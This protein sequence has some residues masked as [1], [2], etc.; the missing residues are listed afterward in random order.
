MAEATSFPC[1]QCGA[2]L[3]HDASS[4]QLKC[5]F[6]GHSQV[7]DSSDKPPIREHDLDGGYAEEGC[8][9]AAPRPEGPRSLHCG[10]CGATVELGEATISTACPYCASPIQEAQSEQDKAQLPTDGLLPFQVESAA[11]KKALKGWV[12]G[13]WFAPGAFKQMGLRGDLKGQFVPHFT[14]D[15]LTSNRYRGE[16]GDAYYVQVPDNDDDGG[17]HRERRVR[18]SP[19]SGA[20]ERH[21]DDEL[22]CALGDE[23]RKLMKELEPWPLAS[24]QPF[25]PEALAGYLATRY[26]RGLKVCFDEAKMAMDAA[27]Y[28]DA[29]RR[30]GGDEQ[31]VKELRS[32]YNQTTYKSLL[33]PVWMMV[34]RYQSKPYQVVVNACTGEVSGQR[35][36]SWVKIGAT[37]LGVA[38][39]IAAAVYFGG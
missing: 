37:A 38:A 22:V 34:Y 7:I 2:D 27:I 39:F 5:G 11:A 3:T 24:L 28:Q 17:T 23:R 29:K 25:H 35:P 32:D 10:D 19:V 31:R 12:S 30:I 14:F 18:W 1:G 36:Y 13:L 26:E 15:A 16:R 9:A 8:L 20:F 33:L 6:C 21:F 4:G